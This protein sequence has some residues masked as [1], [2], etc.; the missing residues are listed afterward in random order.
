MAKS[1]VARKEGEKLPAPA[2]MAITLHIN[3]VAK[4]LNLATVDD[5]S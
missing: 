3:G 1:S 5:A 2:K 4:K